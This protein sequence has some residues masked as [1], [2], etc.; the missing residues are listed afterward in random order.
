MMATVKRGAKIHPIQY[1][2]PPP[3]VVAK[4]MVNLGK[5]NIAITNQMECVFQKFTSFIVVPHAVG[6][7]TSTGDSSP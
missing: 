5:K 3:N 1:K 2:K 6:V 4:S 7:A